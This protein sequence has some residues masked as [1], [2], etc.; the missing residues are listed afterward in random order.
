MQSSSIY[1][2]MKTVISNTQQEA[3]QALTHAFVALFQKIPQREVFIALSGGNTPQKL[4]DLWSEELKQTIDW[5]RVQLFWVDERCVPYNDDES[6][7][8]MT[9]WHLIRHLPLTD[10]QIHRIKG[11]DDPCKEATR[12]SN[13]IEERLPHRQ[14]IPVFD[15]VLLGVGSDGH[16]ASIF[17]KDNHRHKPDELGE[18]K[19]EEACLNTP[20]WCSVTQKPDNGQYRITLTMPVINAANHVFVLVTGKEKAQ[21]MNQVL[22][23]TVLSRQYPISH[24]HGEHGDVTF[25]LDRLAAGYNNDTTSSRLT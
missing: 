21:I 3:N 24:V 15:F 6:N 20:K 16:T 7:F 12:Y 8:K 14:G 1:T 23:H 10:K 13:L 2:P 11:E 4:F 5:S 18:S 17:P 9:Q 22:N 19:S 25:F